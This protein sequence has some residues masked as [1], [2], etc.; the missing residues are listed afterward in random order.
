MINFHELF[1]LGFHKWTRNHKIPMKNIFIK[2]Q[3]ISRKRT[4]NGGKNFQK[5]KWRA[6][7]NDNFQ[8]QK[9]TLDLVLP[10]LALCQLIV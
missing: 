1:L 7:N 8:I 5:I 2:F 10:L 6:E 3:N 4:K 9:M